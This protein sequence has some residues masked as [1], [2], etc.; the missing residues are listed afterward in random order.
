MN[1][2]PSYIPR[3]P[4]MQEILA[5]EL[6]AYSA[7]EFVRGIASSLELAKRGLPPDRECVLEIA[8][9]NGEIM[10]VSRISAEGTSVLRI[11][12]ILAGDA[13][14]MLCHH[15]ALKL[16]CSFPSKTKTTQKPKI[17]FYVDGKEVVP[18]PPNQKDQPR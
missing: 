13:C 8:L 18:S 4:S 5:D 3:M 1:F 6:A 7:R 9:E 16:L 17:G 2:D 12:G 14:L 10:Q 15:S 11:E